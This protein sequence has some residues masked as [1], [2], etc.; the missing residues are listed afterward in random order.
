VVACDAPPVIRSSG[1]LSFG[2]AL[3]GY[4]IHQRRF[5]RGKPSAQATVVRDDNTRPSASPSTNRA[6][7]SEPRREARAPRRTR[8]RRATRSNSTRVAFQIPRDGEPREG[9]T[10]EVFVVACWCPRLTEHYHV[11]GSETDPSFGQSDFYMDHAGYTLRSRYRGTA[12]SR[13]RP[14]Q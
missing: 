6:A 10:D 4:D 9:S 2:L 11:G 5:G 8:S 14:S 1:N 13:R 12:S 3:A 7:S